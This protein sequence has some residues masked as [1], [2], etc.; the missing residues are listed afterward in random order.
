[1]IRWCHDKK[2]K[3]DYMVILLPTTWNETAYLRL[4]MF[5]AFVRYEPL[6]QL[7]LELIF[8]KCLIR[9]EGKRRKYIGGS[10]GLH[11]GALNAKGLKKGEYASMKVLEVILVL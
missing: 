2:N 11:W 10:F 1:M 3:T 6:K 9:K 8:I 7:D 4:N 5:T